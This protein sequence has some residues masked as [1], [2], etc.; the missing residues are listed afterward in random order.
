MS[1]CPKCGA[2]FVPNQRFCQKCGMSLEEEQESYVET[3]GATTSSQYKAEPQVY[4]TEYHGLFDPR[5]EYYVLQEKYWRLG[6]GDILD[7]RGR[8]IGKMNRKIFSLRSKIELVELNGFVS[9]HIQKRFISFAPEFELKDH[10]DRTICKIRK[11][12]WA[13]LR[14]KFY[15]ESTQGVRE[16]MAQGS[17]MGYE[18]DVFSASE[19]GA[20][21]AHV[22]K[23]EVWRS[24]FAGGLFSYN[25]TYAVHIL[26]PNVDRRKILG[27]VLAI[28]NA[29][30][31]N[32]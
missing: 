3:T 8:I 28:D 9:S 30:H 19:T 11:K 17:F 16:F 18:F 4:S 25:D 13:F 7:E 5:H 32:Y 21:V 29:L 1:Y 15:L 14:P 12:V 23:T 6:S 26:D 22:R 2:S 27:L 20:A 24:I 31:D 10:Q